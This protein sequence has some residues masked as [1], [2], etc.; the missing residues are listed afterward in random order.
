MRPYLFAYLLL[1]PCFTACGEQEPDP[2]GSPDGGDAD[3]ATSCAADPGPAEADPELGLCA[4]EGW[5][6]ANPLPQ[7][8][9]V[10]SLYATSPDD[11]WGAAGRAFHWN[12]AAWAGL[13]GDPHQVDRVIGTGPDDLWFGGSLIAHQLDGEL[14][15]YDV[16]PA[17]QSVFGMFRIADDQIWAVGTAGLALRWNGDSWQ[18]KS[19]PTGADIASVWGRGPNDVWAIAAGSPAQPGTRLHWNGTQWQ[20]SDGGAPCTF[21]QVWG[22]DTERGWGRCRSGELEYWNGDQFIE[23]ADPAPGDPIEV[24]GN[25]A[26]AFAADGT[27]RVMHWDGASWTTLL[28]GSLADNRIGFW[29]MFQMP[30]GD[31]LV[32]GDYGAIARCSIDACSWL[33]GGPDTARFSMKAAWAAAA[34]DVWAVGDGIAHFDGARWRP[35]DTPQ[36]GRLYAVHGLSASDVWAVGDSVMHYDGCVWSEIDTGVAGGQLYAVWARAADDVW[37]VGGEVGAGVAIHFDGASWTSHPMPGQMSGVWGTAPDRVWA[38]GEAGTIMRWDGAAWSPEGDWGGDSYAWFEAVWG[39]SDGD[40]WLVGEK[41][42]RGFI[43]HRTGE[44]WTAMSSRRRPDWFLFAL[45]GSGPDDVWAAG[46]FGRV[47]HWDGM[48]WTEPHDLV[49]QGALEGIAVGPGGSWLVGNWGV[50][51]HHP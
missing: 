31:V 3:A 18:D 48:D 37:A 13:E 36:S 33:A 24:A 51:L 41:D 12:G 16:V 15:T 28:E 9:L 21:L 38:V 27:G 8:N 34:S 23:I 11:V 42:Y 25:A 47:M 6:F 2:A 20:Q 1:V 32:G 39:T 7:P 43:A 5:C 29:S 26:S 17:E 10:T 40:L 4:G 46:N 44:E 50:I 30:D 45:G 14:T 35:V 49:I 19:M 22:T